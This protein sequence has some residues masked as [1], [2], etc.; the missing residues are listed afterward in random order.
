[1]R[2]A[3][4]AVAVTIALLAM[5]GGTATATD[6]TPC[7]SPTATSSRTTCPTPAPTPDPNQAA[8]D[9]LVARLTGD[10][11][12]ALTAEHRL[13]QTLDQ[14]AGIEQSL[15]AQVAQEE[16][17][18]SRLQD[19]I[20]SLDS[21]IADTQARIDVEKQELAVLVRSLYRQPDSFWILIARTGSLREA[22]IAT[23]DA[24]IAGQRAHALQDR[25]EQDLIKLQSDRDARQADLDRESNTRDLLVANLNSLQDVMSQ[26]TAVSGELMGVMTELRTAETQVRNQPPS[27]TADL[28][29][30]LEA[31]E[32]DLIL[33]SYQTA[34]AQAEVGA[35]QALVKNALPLGK[36]IAGLRLSWPLAH[37][38]I[39]QGFGPTTFG[40]EPPLGPYKHFHTG[41]DIS[42]PL[43]SP[44]MAAADGVVVAVGS[45][46]IG[47]GNYVVIAHGGGIET[48][49]G[50]LLK[51]DVS[52]GQV[53]GRGQV[54]GL[55]GS[56]GYSTGPHV[57]FELRVNDLVTDPMPYL[58]V[59]G[60]TWNS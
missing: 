8:Y 41:I 51:A 52:V 21:Q 43:G 58:P 18:I 34:W 20:A 54:I 25:L 46:A 50:H 4:G 22:L 14:F 33:R 45:D 60:T 38:T 56:T 2:K 1:M 26:Q 37:F 16:A 30:L 27:V 11:A 5:Q 35:G 23:A 59:P 40:L 12:N 3:F 10:I 29:Q 53:V 17:T 47:Y 36:T 55:E 39:T 48:L 24:V 42:A 6:T 9:A 31:Q 44:V 49:Y 19:E 7:A 57:H 28:A 13:S 15:T 32:Q